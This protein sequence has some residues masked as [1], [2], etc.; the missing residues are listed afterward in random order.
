MQRFQRT[1]GIKVRLSQTPDAMTSSFLAMDALAK[2][3][4][5]Y[6]L[7]DEPTIPGLAKV[8]IKIFLAWNYAT[9]EFEHSQWLVKVT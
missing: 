4:R 6:K 3:V 1:R 2:L 9:L 8:A 7:Q 5:H